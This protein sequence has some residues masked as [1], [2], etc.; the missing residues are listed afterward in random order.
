M[1]DNIVPFPHKDTV[2]TYKA[3]TYNLDNITVNL[4]GFDCGVISA[5]DWSYDLSDAIRDIQRDKLKTELDNLYENIKDRPECWE[6]VIASINRL[7][8]LY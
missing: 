6:M 7:S 1:M 2:N 4:N 8:S 5:S 3:H